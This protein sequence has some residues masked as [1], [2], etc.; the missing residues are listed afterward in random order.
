MET[1]NH[2]RAGVQRPDRETR[3]TE[4]SASLNVGR[5]RAVLLCGP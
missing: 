5:F 4:S 3:Q 2:D 1:V